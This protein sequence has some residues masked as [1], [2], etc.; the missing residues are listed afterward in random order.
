MTL[1]LLLWME[2]SLHNYWHVRLSILWCFPYY[3]FVGSGR[4]VV[5]RERCCLGSEYC[6][7]IDHA[8]M[9]SLELRLQQT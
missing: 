9:Y 4:G 8:C 5:G 7:Y 1:C 3:M 6:G 2:R